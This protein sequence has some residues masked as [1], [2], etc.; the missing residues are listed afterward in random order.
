M[1]VAG[2]AVHF[3]T[4]RGWGLNTEQLHADI[5]WFIRSRWGEEKR[6]LIPCHISVFLIAQPS[7]SGGTW[8]NE[9]ALPFEGRRGLSIICGQECWNCLLI[10]V[11]DQQ[12]LGRGPED[13]DLKKKTAVGGTKGTWCKCRLA[14]FSKKAPWLWAPWKTMGCN[15]F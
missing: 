6:S 11:R 14:W 8:L 2:A 12:P 4:D 3:H 15:L 9:E 5:H 7:P 1:A 10:K 13:L